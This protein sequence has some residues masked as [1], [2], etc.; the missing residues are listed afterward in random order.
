MAARR[1]KDIAG[2]KCLNKM[3]K[4]R[5]AD[6]TSACRFDIPT[7]EQILMTNRS[8]RLRIERKLRR[9]RRFPLFFRGIGC[10]AGVQIRG[11]R[12]RGLRRHIADPAYRRF[13]ATVAA[14]YRQSSSPASVGWPADTA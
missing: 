8:E 14:A 5:A 2:T 7:S 13:V 4:M 12:R 1:C 9:E 6:V 3:S 11:R 10:S